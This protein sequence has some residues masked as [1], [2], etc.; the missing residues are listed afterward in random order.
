M[1][2]NVVI[3][4]METTLPLPPDRVLNAAIEAD[5]DYVA[6]VGRTKE[7]EFYFAS[8]VADGPATMWD[9]EKAKAML[10]SYQR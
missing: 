8:S 3:L 5:L 2:D 9:L 1:A 6:V 4:H 7:G 10:M